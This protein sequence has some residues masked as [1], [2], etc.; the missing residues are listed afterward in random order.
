MKVPQKVFK[1]RDE[2]GW[3]DKTTKDY[4][5]GKRVVVVSLPG[6]F[7]PIWSIQHLPR[8]EDNYDKFLEK[9][10]DDVYCISVNDAFVMNAWGKELGIEKVKLI[11]D[12]D[13]KFTEGM[14]MLVHKPAQGF[15]YRS[16]RY[17]M[18]VKDGEVEKMWIEPGK[19]QLG[20]DNDP[21][22]QTSPSRILNE[23]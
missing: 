21:Y 5:F 19:N 20:L 22:G 8:L 11:P 12:G 2:S 7:T 1:T 4:F 13:G 10:F 15:G 23:C 18:T 9:G 14:D 3:V 17:A 16:W 6:A